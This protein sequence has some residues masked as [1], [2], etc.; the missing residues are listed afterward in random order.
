MSFEVVGG[1]LWLFG[2]QGGEGVGVA[3][4]F[5]AIF[6]EELG[7]AVALV[8]RV[9]EAEVDEEGFF[10]F[11]GLAVTE[12]VHDLLA[13]PVGAGFIGFAALGGVFDDLEFAVGDAVAVSLFAG[14]H[15]L[16]ASVVKEFWK[17]AWRWWGW[18]YCFFAA[19]FRLLSDVLGDAPDALTGHDHGAGTGAD[20]TAPGTHVVGAIED[21]AFFCE[22]VD[23]WGIE[24]GLGVV[25]LEI[26][27]RL[28]ID[29]DEEKIGFL[30]RCGREK[31]KASYEG[32]KKL[33][34]RKKVTRLSFVAFHSASSA[35][36]GVIALKPA[37]AALPATS[38]LV[39]AALPT[40]FTG[41]VMSEQELRRRG[42]KRS[43]RRNI[44]II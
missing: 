28:I 36:P 2:V 34:V 6:G 19:F 39:V 18:F 26:K 37:P 25:N 42:R 17:C 23:V 9:G 35:L 44:S 8:V 21:E 3:V 11:L 29:D 20:R 40:I 4:I 32:E 1:E 7:L 15:G 30:G 38:M 33:H 14:A 27:G 5:C 12:V 10:G 43:E 31:A 13:V 16:V 22:A 41:V 24:G